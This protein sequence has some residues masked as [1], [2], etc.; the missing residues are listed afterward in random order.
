MSRLLFIPVSALNGL[1]AGF[2]GKKT[3]RGLWSLLDKQEPPDPKQ[4]DAS[5]GKVI[6][7]LLLQGAVFGAARGIVDRASRKGFSRLTGSWPGEGDP[8]RA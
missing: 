5:W 1:L 6:A 2:I 8:P 7:A 4:R 3:F